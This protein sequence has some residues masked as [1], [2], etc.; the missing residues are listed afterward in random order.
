MMLASFL[1][2]LGEWMGWVGAG[3]GYGRMVGSMRLVRSGWSFLTRTE[4]VSGR[5]ILH[6]LCGHFV[7][8]FIQVTPYKS[9]TY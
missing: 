3:G 1:V 6:F 9:S 8:K 5:L 2:W 7:K 4:P